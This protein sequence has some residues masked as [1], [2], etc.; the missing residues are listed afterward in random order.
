MKLTLTL[1]FLAFKGLAE[2]IYCALPRVGEKEDACQEAVIHLTSK[3]GKFTPGKAKAL[4][5][6][7]VVITRHFSGCYRRITNK[8][9]APN[10]VHVT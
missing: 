6:A 7:Y 9:N 5:W 10:K 1:S 4:T 8:Y 2:R 3:L